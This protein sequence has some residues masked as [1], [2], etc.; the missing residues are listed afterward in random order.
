M[1]RPVSGNRIGLIGAPPSARASTRP[2]PSV[3]TL[4][5]AE[6]DGGKSIAGRIG[7]CQSV[8]V[9]TDRQL[10]EFAGDGYVV[11]RDVVPAALRDRAVARIDALLTERPPAD[12]H[13]GHHTYWLETAD[14]PDLAALLIGSAAMTWAEALTAPREMDVP[15]GLQWR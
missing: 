3:S 14:E 8:R 10:A 4:L 15:A 11:A 6:G 12:G 1:S 9:W 13:T 2:A 7:I 5:A